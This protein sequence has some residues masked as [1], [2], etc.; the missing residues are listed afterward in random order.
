MKKI[1]IGIDL[2]TTYSGAAMLDGAGFPDMIPNSR[3]KNL[4][5]SVVMI[6][7]KKIIVGDSAK[8][9]IFVKPDNVID[10]VKRFIGT[11]KKYLLDGE[12]H[13]PITISSIILKEIKKDVEEITGSEI[14]KAVISVP[15]NFGNQQREETLQAAKNADLDV[16]FIINEPT[17]AALAYTK[18]AK[19]KEDGLYAIYD[20]GGGTFDCTIVEINGENVDIKIS[21]GVQKLGGKDL[22]LKLLNIVQEKYKNLTGKELENRKYSLNHAEKDKIELSDVEEVLIF[23]DDLTIAVSREEFEHSISSLI[24][25]SLMS[26]ETALDGINATFEDLKE[27]VLV[28]GTTRVPLV[29]SSLESLIGKPP[30]SHGNPDEA[31]ALGAAIYASKQ[32]PEFLNA[33]QKTTIDMLEISEVCNANFGTFILSDSEMGKKIKNSIIIKKGTNIP[34]SKL[35]SYQTVYDNQT[36]LDCSITECKE[37]EIDI[38]FV[39]VIWK[40]I[41]D[42]PDGRPAG[43]PVNI[44]YSYNINQ[45]MDCEFHDLDSGR[46]LNRTVNFSDASSSDSHE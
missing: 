2:G 15:A 4:T 3:G 16:D 7:N 18:S 42:L 1:V 38:K 23:I 27:L 25:Q 35:R 31:V 20:F 44:T 6:E 41:L 12:E 32:Y 26:I 45:T 43:K 19:S 11:D 22:D 30:K 8:K 13:S 39:D 34:C 10:E 5:P 29:K 24:Q 17:A 36:S 21:E 14:A 9:K 28:G 46:K 40:G 37:Q 33:N